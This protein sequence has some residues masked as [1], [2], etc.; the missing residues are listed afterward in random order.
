MNPLR[1][2]RRWTW[3]CAWLSL[4]LAFAEQAS[5]IEH[6]LVNI[7]GQQRRLSGKVLI[8]DQVGG[9]LLET[10]DG[11]LWPLEAR[12]VR[13]RASD[14]EPL[15]PLTKK[16][17]GERLLE[18][19]GPTF[20]VHNSKHYVVV[21]NTTRTYAKWCSSLL[22][23]LQKGF[24][25]YWK[26]RGCDVSEPDIPLA[27]LV[28][29]DQ[30]SY[31]RHAKQELGEGVGN[32]IG[33]YNIQTN[34][35]VMYDLTGMQELRKKKG[36]RGTIHDITAL[37]SQ[38][39]AGPLVATVV[40]EAT[41]QIAFNCGLQTRLNSSPVWLSEGLAVYCETPDLTNRRGGGTIGAINHA[42][43]DRF[44]KNVIEGKQIGIRRLV[45][46]DEVIRQ[47][48]TAV[49]AY[50]AAWAWNYYLIKWRSDDYVAYLKTLADKPQLVLYDEG[51][52]L[53]DFQAHFGEDLNALKKDFYRRMSR[54]K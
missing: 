42:R 31:M 43:W 20:Q 18:Q 51:E 12:S 33:Y 30:A 23:R 19:M 54:L 21:Y 8:E 46:N 41:H 3:P 36:R 11:A 4:V 52:R 24:L 37:L 16:Q 17:L 38:P 14:S 44:R 26:D 2:Y 6:V 1:R 7:D 13:D 25:A 48:D 49:D 53:A 39:E 47:P 15:T 9:M 10:D 22:E 5:A 35:I 40:H 28:F 45:V 50:A 29:S 32:A 34:R 27:V